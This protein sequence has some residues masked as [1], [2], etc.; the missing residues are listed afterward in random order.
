MPLRPLSL[1]CLLLSGWLAAQTPDINE[2]I[3]VQQ[4]PEP[5]NLAEVRQRIVYP[6]SA[7][8]DNIQGTVVA[9]V[10]IDTA[11]Q[12]VQHKIVKSVAP[13]LDAAVVAALPQLQFTPAQQDGRPV[14]YW[15]NLP[16]PFRLVNEQEAQLKD[17]ID[18]LTQELT[19][20]PDNYILWHQRGIQRSQLGD[21]DYAR[22]DFTESIAQN[23]QKNKKRKGESYAY[24][25]YAYFGRGQV[26]V[27]QEKYEQALADFDAALSTAQEMKAEDSAVQATV[28][29]VYLER[30]YTHAL[31]EHYDAAV[32]DL[33]RV[34]EQA[35]AQACE[36]YPLLADVGLAADDKALLVRAYD[37]LVTCQPG[38]YSYRYSRG[39]YRSEAGDYEG[40]LQDMDSVAAHSE[41]FPLRLAAHN[42]AAWCYLQLDQLDQAEAALDQALLLNAVNHLSHYYRGLLLEAQG[43]PLD[44][45]QAMSKAIYFGL[46]GPEGDA[47]RN[48]LNQQCGE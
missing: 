18:E 28:P 47:A 36:V 32:R 19:V 45:C 14:M 3:Y 10:L 2:F 42:H 30:G 25:F 20:D 34:L 21:L 39:Y 1:L 40:G 29:Q 38:E 4:E 9:R 23:P 37:G 24:L 15:M 13:E 48:Y 33:D 43:Q 6:E 11:G 26:Y 44:A 7:V 5:L 41:Q 27:Q 35:P 8:T 31:A 16:F 46:E 17:R 22:G 12:Y